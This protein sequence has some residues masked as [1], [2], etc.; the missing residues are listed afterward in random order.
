L[1]LTIGMPV[2]S[3]S[4]AKSRS[5]GALFR[6]ATSN[7]SASGAWRLAHTI[8]L[9]LLGTEIELEATAASRAAHPPTHSSA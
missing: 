8:T 2:G 1:T 7:R 9:T 5:S 6:S 3:A 4:T